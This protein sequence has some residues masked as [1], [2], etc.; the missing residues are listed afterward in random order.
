MIEEEGDYIPPE[1]KQLQ[2]QDE[3][4]EKDKE[5]NGIKLRLFPYQNN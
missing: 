5:I 1:R 3:G 2:D 4:F